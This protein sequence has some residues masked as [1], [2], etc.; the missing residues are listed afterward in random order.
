M[1]AWTPR[2][3]AEGHRSTVGQV[4]VGPW[5]DRTGWSDGFAF[6][7]G[8]SAVTG[9]LPS[10]AMVAIMVLQDFNTLILRDGMRPRIVHEA[11]LAIAEYRRAI[12]P[13]I[14]GAGG[15]GRPRETN[16]ATRPW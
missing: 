10:K 5:P 9:H 6:H 8:G 16:A 11:M 12:D 4:K 13:E 2:S 1:I 15:A 3:E 7:G 14:P